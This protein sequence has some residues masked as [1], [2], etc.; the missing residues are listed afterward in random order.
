MS[1]RLELAVEIR[2][3][4]AKHAKLTPTVP[5]EWSSPDAYELEAAAAALE[6]G[7]E[8]RYPHSE[9]GSGGYQP[10]VDAKAQAWHDRIIRSVLIYR[11]DEKKP[12]EVGKTP[13][14]VRVPTK[15]FDEYPVRMWKDE[16]GDIMGILEGLPGFITHAAT[17][18]ECLVGLR[19]L[20]VLWM[21]AEKEMEV[22]R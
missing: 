22:G 19:S 1:D 18:E 5:A 12:E 14:K 10:Y 8:V 7:G 13:Q 3:F 15:A 17:H 9:W 16:D 6:Q 11:T 2:S 21:E 4:L 20:Y